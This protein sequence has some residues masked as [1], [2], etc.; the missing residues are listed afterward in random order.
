M[1]VVVVVTGFDNEHV[2]YLWFK[3]SS[4]VEVYSVQNEKRVTK[5]LERDSIKRRG[6]RDGVRGLRVPDFQKTVGV[7][8]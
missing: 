7:S 6:K 4:N 8:F 5:F 3:G 1:C 2:N